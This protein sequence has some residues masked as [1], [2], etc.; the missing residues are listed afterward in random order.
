[1]GPL[2]PQEIIAEGWNFLIA[3]IIGIG[4]GFVLEQAGFSSSR[5]LA[6]VFYGYDAVVL[7]VFFTATITAM[8]G[9]LYFSLFDWIDLNLVWVNPTYLWS[10]IIGGIIMGAGFII[11]GFCPG[12]SV[13]AVAIGKIDAMIFLGGIFIGIFIFGESYSFIKPLYFAKSMGNIKLSDFLDISSGFLALLVVIIAL[14]MFYI[15]EIIEKKF[16]RKEY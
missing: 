12:T 5:K 6:G 14:F 10:A 2:I 3:F 11:G 1:M 9:L 16:P 7:K 8:L 15:A 4:F 13:C